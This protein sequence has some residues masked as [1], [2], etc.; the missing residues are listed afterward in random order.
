VLFQNRAFGFI[1]AYNRLHGT[2]IQGKHGADVRNRRNLIASTVGIIALAL[3]VLPGSITAPM[4]QAQAPAAQSASADD[5]RP[6]FDTA[7][8]KPN[9]SAPQGEK[10]TSQIRTQPGGRFTATNAL[11]RNL[12]QHAYQLKPVEG[13]LISGVPD[14]ANSAFFD[15][16][17]KAEGNPTADQIRLMEQSLIA[18]RFKLVVH[19]ETRQAPVYALV[20][21]KMGKPGPQLLPHSDA[22]DCRKI[23]PSRPLPPLDPNSTPPPPPSCG[24]ITGGEN[25]LAGNKVT[26]EMLA[27]SLGAI[28]P[29]FVGRP[30][31]DRTGLAGVFD[32]EL[33]FATL[34]PPPSGSQPSSDASTADSTA[35]PDIFTALPEQLGLR[36]ESTK[37]P[38]DVLV[39][40]HV[41]EPSP[42]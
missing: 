2:P 33:K 9:K 18:E 1:R 38:V 4:P 35:L 34:L 16:E 3:P 8:I 25:R 24:G 26:M 12:I 28:L 27:T 31:V 41:E 36:L 30:V 39:I 13:R 11:L 29:P 40:D 22:A 21:A 20:V 14:W 42:N 10:A 6:A 19:H 5:Q 7:S 15:I 32:F 17:A 37:G 23:D